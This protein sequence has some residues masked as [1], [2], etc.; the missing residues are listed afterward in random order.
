MKRMAEEDV[1]ECAVLQNI[2]TKAKKYKLVFDTTL[3]S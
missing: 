2:L 3:K 1:R